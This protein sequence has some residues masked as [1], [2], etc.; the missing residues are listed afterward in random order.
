MITNA[1]K[2]LPWL[3]GFLLCANLYLVPSF[4]ASPRATDAM[5]A[6]LG[7]WALRRLA[8]GRL[9]LGTLAVLAV[10]NVLPAVWLLLSLLDPDMPT[11][12]QSLRWLFAVPWALALVSLLATEDERRRFAWGLVAGCWVNIAVVM[13]QSVGIEAPLRLVGLS[14][15]DA[16][17]HHYV[18]NQVR[19]PGMHG[20]HAAS[21]AVI[22]LIVPASLYL[23]FRKHAGLVIPLSALGGFLYALNLTSTRSPLIIAAFTLAYAFVVARQFG[24]GFVFG[25]IGIAVLVPAMLVLGPPGGRNRWEDALALQANAGERFESNFASADLAL[26]HPLGLGVTGGQR[27]LYDL[28]GITATH[29]AYLQAAVFVGLPLA[30]LILVTVTVVALRGLQGPH[31]P[32]ML[33][34]LLAFHTAGLFLF[35]EHLNNP[36]FVILASW[37]IAAAVRRQPRAWRH[38]VA[39]NGTA[40]AA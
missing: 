38:Q 33:L 21:S 14:S 29:N 9:P 22:S 39:A 3:L 13:L 12:A 15:S 35:E 20:H 31:H 27:A 28:S 26:L 36:T 18:Y 10:A 2:H 8:A 37:F 32:D 23:Y 40:T 19:L 11:I 1:R 34:A 24:R 5:A 25:L 6:V 7:I 16:V 17:Y 30:L 4:A